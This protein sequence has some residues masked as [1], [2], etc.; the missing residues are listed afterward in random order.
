ML[1]KA[2]FTAALLVLLLDPITC[3]LSAD[4]P[5]A[6]TQSF[7]GKVVPLAGLLEKFGSRLDPEAAPQWLALVTK[8]GA[9]YPLIRDDGSRLFFADSTPPESADA[10]DGAA[11]WG[12]ASSSGALRKQLRERRADTRC[13]TGATCARFAEMRSCRDASAAAGQCN[14]E[15]CR[16]RSR[17]A[18]PG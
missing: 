16:S 3:R 12:H 13:T 9:V 14:C 7:D 4:P 10:L 5:N 8:Q 18:F 2:F 1:L 11:L 6:K 17:S 15:R